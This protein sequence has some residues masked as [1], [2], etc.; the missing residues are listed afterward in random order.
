MLF[1]YGSETYI[2]LELD[3]FYFQSINFNSFTDF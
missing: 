3:L 2:F 1:K